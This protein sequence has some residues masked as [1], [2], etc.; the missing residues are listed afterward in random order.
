M[1]EKSKKKLLWRAKKHIAKPEDD[2]LDVYYRYNIM[3]G[4][5]KKDIIWWFNSLQRL[6]Q[7]NNRNP[8]TCARGFCEISL[9]MPIS[10]GWISRGHSLFPK[11]I[12]KD[13]NQANRQPMKLQH[14]AAA[15]SVHALKKYDSNILLGIYRATKSKQICIRAGKDENRKTLGKTYD[16]ARM[17]KN[18]IYRQRCERLVSLEY[19][20]NIEKRPVPF[21]IK[22]GLFKKIMDCR[23]HMD[24]TLCAFLKLG[25]AYT[26]SVEKPYHFN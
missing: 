25:A 20:E 15:S 22:C 1:Y 17:V 24:C 13:S 11:A 5:F 6:W 4:S 8:I 18:Y 2:L 19:F 16:F 9:T 10:F 26:P 3:S 12:V 21:C 23:Y 7:E 14:I